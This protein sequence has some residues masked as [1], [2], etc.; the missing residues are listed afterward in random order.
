MGTNYYLSSESIQP[1]DCD[2]KSLIH[3]GKQSGGWPFHWDLALFQV[4]K[5]GY[6]PRWPLVS[7][8][9][10]QVV[11][12]EVTNLDEVIPSVTEK[13]VLDI[14]QSKEYVLIRECG[15]EMDVNEFWNGLPR[16]RHPLCP[17]GYFTVGT[18]L[19]TSYTDFS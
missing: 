5:Y 14:L 6:D 16:R 15:S 9:W 17:E 1:E 10:D 8:Y 18:L 7:K 4:W 12:Q 3:V 19:F 2:G 13:D 11:R